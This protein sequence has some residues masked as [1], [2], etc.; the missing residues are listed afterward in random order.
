MTGKTHKYDYE[1]KDG[2]APSK[3]ISMVGSNARVLELGSGPG[4]ITRNLS[5]NGC[6]VVA[7]DIDE[8]AL[9]R[10]QQYARFSYHCDLDQPG[11]PSQLP[12]IGRFDAV[13][14]A[15]VFEHLRHPETSL[16]NVHDFLNESGSLVLSLPHVGHA[17]ILAC[18]LNSDF[19]YQSSGLLDRTHI[20]FF[21]LQNMQ[22]LLESARFK[23]IE[24]DYVIRR[25]EN[26]ELADYWR[27]LNPKVQDILLR[28][29]FSCVYQVVLRAVPQNR[30]GC[31][32]HVAD[33]RPM[34]PER[35]SIVQRY[36]RNGLGGYMASFLSPESR[37]RITS[38][39]KKLG[40]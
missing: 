13:V 39:F 7:L 34:K 33:Y 23:I 19:R 1:V 12:A 9:E 8:T 11:W 40:L 15:D 36:G 28:Q 3:V 27:E 30:P 2:G 6:E 14:A 32:L 20:R 31:P 35:L 17:A 21:G 25:P 26:T 18:Q 4:S 24:I 29:R 37:E 5:A 38:G 22:E 16:L 10:V